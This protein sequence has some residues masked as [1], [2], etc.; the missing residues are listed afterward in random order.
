VMSSHLT[1]IQVI[2]QQLVGHSS[3]VVGCEII[4]FIL[5]I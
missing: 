4:F 5:I 1:E 3:L 2:T